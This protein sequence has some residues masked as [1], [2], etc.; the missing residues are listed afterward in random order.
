[1]FELTSHT[2]QAKVHRSFSFRFSSE[3]STGTCFVYITMLLA[4]TARV[5][6]EA[7]LYADADWLKLI[8]QSESGERSLLKDAS[9]LHLVHT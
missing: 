4:Q 1:M 8:C 7:C 2:A 6:K 9:G 3:N 5:S